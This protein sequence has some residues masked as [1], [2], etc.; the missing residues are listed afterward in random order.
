MKTALA[1][2]ISAMNPHSD[3]GSED[4]M[5]SGCCI[6]LSDMEP[7][8]ALFLAPCSHCFHYKCCTPL[9]A[10]GYMFQCP[11]CR[12]VANL[13]A[14]VNQDEDTDDEVTSTL[15]ESE[16]V[17]AGN[18]TV[19]ES[20]TPISR[21]MSLPVRR[22]LHDSTA[23]AD[24][25]DNEEGSQQGEGLSPTSSQPMDIPSSSSGPSGTILAG[26]SGNRSMQL[27]QTLIGSS[28]LMTPPNNTRMLPSATEESG[29]LDESAGLTSNLSQLGLNHSTAAA[30][31]SQERRQEMEDALLEYEHALNR[32]SCLFPNMG[33]DP[34][35]LREILLQR[36]REQGP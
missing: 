19:K 2:L 20:N 29:G 3:E 13:E 16:N 6:C 4:P 7:Y 36:A 30:N 8:Q 22:T 21:A 15:S 33:Q 35:D 34:Q 17:A 12:Q 23:S 14:D 24:E 26:Q 10:T 9:L 25:E 11:L 27:Q 28:S 32:L 5:S 31:T 1:Y 18:S